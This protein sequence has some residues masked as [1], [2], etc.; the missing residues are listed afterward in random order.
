[1]EEFEEL[2]IFAEILPCKSNSLAFP[3]GGF[4]L[5]F[6]ISTKL[7]HDHM[8][9]KTGCG[10]LVIGYHKGGDLCLLE[11]GLV[12]EAQNGDFIFFRSRD[13]S[14]FNLHY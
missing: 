12:I 14:Y 7:H 13:I 3:F 9:L 6:N 11:P 4:V 1:P 2:H 8:D 10:V 5:N